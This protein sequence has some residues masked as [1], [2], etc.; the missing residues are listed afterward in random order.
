MKRC[1]P[2][3]LAGEA[4]RSVEGT[5]FPEDDQEI[6]RQEFLS[7]QPETPEEIAA[8]NLAQELTDYAYSKGW[9]REGDSVVY[10][11]GGYPRDLM[12]RERGWATGR[13]DID[14]AT[15]LSWQQV[16]EFLARS[17]L[18]DLTVEKDVP[19]EKKTLI[20]RVLV[21]DITDMIQFEVASFRREEDYADHLPQKVW[22]SR[23]LC[24]DAQRRDF[25]INALYFDP[26]RKELLD[27]VGGLEDLRERRLR[28]V[29]DVRDRLE[30]DPV[31]MLRYV[32]FLCPL[33]MEGDPELEA[34]VLQ[35]ADLLQKVSPER[36]R[37]EMEA[38]Y[39]RSHLAESIDKLTSLGL[40]DQVLPPEVL[41]GRFFSELEEV[42]HPSEAPYHLEGDVYQHTL[43]VLRALQ[44]ERLL[45]LYRL[46]VE[47][48][49]QD[50]EV[51]GDFLSSVEEA[52]AGSRGS[53]QEMIAVLGPEVV[54]AS[55]LHDVGKAE[56]RQQQVDG[57]VTFH[58]HARVSAERS[59][60]AAKN[61]HMA[62]REV[63]DLSWLAE[64][65]LRVWKFSQMRWGK[66]EDLYTH[67]AFP[68]LVVLGLADYLGTETEEAHQPRIDGFFEELDR[69]VKQRTALREEEHE[70]VPVNG[71]DVMA[72]AGIGSGPRVGQI[73][74]KIRKKCEQFFE[75]Q[76][77]PP[78]RPTVLEWIR[79][80]AGG[81][82][83]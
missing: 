5:G 15:Q 61:L 18:R 57:K 20:H 78:D 67:R 65:H 71:H 48:L 24:E 2:E 17:S 53:Y 12:L 44:S 27:P 1:Y 38:I 59:E 56:T 3:N 19:S 32:R 54:W 13:G 45:E 11:V 33:G 60:A 51:F 74:G 25:T 30:E 52:T 23:S 37:G 83:T 28:T 70:V 10:F 76:N 49:G 73:L 6:P 41:G 75:R 22:P 50:E 36:V 39:R 40:M 8:V 77:R 42:E 7:W 29:G 55:L 4:Q 80:E 16:A 69:F 79:Q 68:A 43:G 81:I 63:A 14:L 58:R 31:R 21:P 82:S 72:E 35:N 62:N 47:I 64:Q 26:I 66:K 46:L 9:V 34:F